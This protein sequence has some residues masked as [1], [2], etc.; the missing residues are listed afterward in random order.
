MV[1]KDYEVVGLSPPFPTKANAVR[2]TLIKT[3]FTPFVA[4]YVEAARRRSIGT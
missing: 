3:I 1:R 4:N 2:I